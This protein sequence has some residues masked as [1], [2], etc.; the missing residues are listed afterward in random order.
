MRASRAPAPSKRFIPQSFSGKRRQVKRSDGQVRSQLQ[1]RGRSQG[2]RL[3][4][5]HSKS[6]LRG[7]EHAVQEIH[8][9]FR[10]PA[11][12]VE[13]WIEDVEVHARTARIGDEAAED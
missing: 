12:R 8:Q 1:A 9:P 3:A 7:E 13:V 2:L 5:G 6:A 11:V 4:S 10:Q